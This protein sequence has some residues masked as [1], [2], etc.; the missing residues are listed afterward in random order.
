M[1]N[2]DGTLSKIAATE[3]ERGTYREIDWNNVSQYEIKDYIRKAQ[4]LK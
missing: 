2:L 3:M 1:D 4:Y